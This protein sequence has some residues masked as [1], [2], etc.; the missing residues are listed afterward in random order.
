MI[1]SANRRGFSL[2]EILVAMVILGVLGAAFTR[3]LMVQS[4]FYDKENSRRNA[5]AVARNS[6]NVLLSDLRMVQDTL[7][8]ET[9]TT[10]GRSIT[11]RVPY[12]FGLVCQANGVQVVA[13]ML[14]A[15][16]VVAALSQFAGYAIRNANGIYQTYVPSTTLPD[17][18]TDPT[19]CTGSAFGQ[20]QIATISFNGRTGR[21][22]RLVPGTLATVGSSLFLWQ[23]VRYYFAESTIMPGSGRWGLFR[24]VN[25]GTAEELMAPF[26][27]LARF[28][29]YFRGDDTSRTVYTLADTAKIKGL[30]VVLTGRSEATPAGQTS[31]VKSRMVSSVFFK[32][33][34][35][36]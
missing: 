18:A 12:R 32:N 23:R 27:S 31:P 2:V 28:R 25:G 30:D 10:D 19:V 16:S 8:V 14:P 24:S 33:V 13:S 6:M 9:L 3:V 29:V 15:D 20:A 17:P 35:A 4:R 34:R 11:L 36:F 26:D 7:G 1:R 21:V 5:R 22:V